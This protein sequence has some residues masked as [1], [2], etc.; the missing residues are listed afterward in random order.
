MPEVVLILIRSIMAFIV[1]LILSRIMGKQQLSQLTF[2]DYIVGIT[3]GSIAASMSVDQNIKILNGFASLVVWG[4]FPVLLSIL[5]MKSFRFHNLTSGKP[6]V[7]IK[8]GELQEE[9]LKK[10]KMSFGDLMAMLR[11][12]QIYKLS[13]VELAVMEING[14]LSVMKKS[15]AQPITPK[16]LSMQLEEEHEPRI[17]VLDGNLMQKSLNESG[18]SKEWLLGEVQKQ[19][20]EDFKDVFLAQIDSKGNVYVDL[21]QDQL[22]KPPVKQKPLVAAALKKVAADLETFALQTNDE[23]TKQLYGE[24]AKKMQRLIVDLQPYLKE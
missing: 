18:Y 21:Y 5:S 3:I 23:K 11:N 10:E 7:M 22:K 20:A 8:N 13:D 17:L 24:Q 2:F 4:I 12:K 15:E 6:T 16:I 1:L 14:K 9:N 19:G